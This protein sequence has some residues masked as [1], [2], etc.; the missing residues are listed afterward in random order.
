MN[1]EKQE[2][3]IKFQSPS[4][5]ILSFTHNAL[6]DLRCFS[7][8]CCA[9]AFFLGV[10]SY[11]KT[12]LIF[13]FPSTDE[14][15]ATTV[16]FAAQDEAPVKRYNVPQ[17]HVSRGILRHQ[18]I[19]TKR[20]NPAYTS[21]QAAVIAPQY[22]SKPGYGPAPRRNTLFRKPSILLP[23]KTTLLFSPRRNIASFARRNPYYTKQPKLLSPPGRKAIVT[24]Y[25]YPQYQQKYMY[26]PRVKYP[27]P[28]LNA[29]RRAL[30][31][32]T[33]AQRRTPYILRK[34]MIVSPASMR[35]MTSRFYYR[36][37][38]SAR[39]YRPGVYAVR[40]DHSW[41]GNHL[42]L[43][44][45][46]SS[47]TQSHSILKAPGHTSTDTHVVNKQQTGGR[48]RGVAPAPKDKNQVYMAQKPKYPFI[49][50]GSRARGQV[51]ASAKVKA[52]ASS[53][54]SSASSSQSGSSSKT[55]GGSRT[56]ASG[57]WGGGAGA[58]WGSGPNAWGIG[59]GG[60]G[61]GSNWKIPSNMVGIPGMP[62]KFPGIPQGFPG[63]PP[64]GYPSQ[65]TFTGAG[66]P[67]S[68]KRP[69]SN[70]KGKKVSLKPN[71]G[72][73]EKAFKDQAKRPMSKAKASSL[74]G[75]AKSK[76]Y[77]RHPKSTLP[78][79][80]VPGKIYR[81]QY[82]TSDPLQRPVSNEWNKLRQR[83]ISDVMNG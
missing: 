77:T 1:G 11:L 83:I 55:N 30:M 36:Q 63:M 62:G 56:T 66:K 17:Y 43:N 31:Y 27:N 24:S 28:Y 60:G 6:Y 23:Q 64:G 52:K 19:I 78:R 61:G 80:S 42:N 41:S 57:G 58:G 22:Y 10:D 40:R 7:A 37:P 34:P 39:S 73:K 2:D 59:Y 50:K 8:L 46:T 20:Y 74:K 32:R 18:P 54:S 69:S 44:M 79:E 72:L 45:G 53:S 75:G 76:S 51:S 47:H 12:F 5:Y 65:G 68:G 29:Q 49:G 48:V 4:K 33:F 25:N 82:F 67:A 3:R 38:Y 13:C 21:Y 70:L 26:T 16:P 81:V 14:A 9:G 35:S 15:A 71:K